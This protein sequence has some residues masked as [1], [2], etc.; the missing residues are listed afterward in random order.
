MWAGAQLLL[1]AAANVSKL[2][3]PHRDDGLTADLRRLLDA[4]GATALRDR[5]LR[6]SFEHLDERI[7]AWS[8][9]NLGTQFTDSVIVNSFD[10]LPRPMPL[11]AF[12]AADF[13]VILLG[14]SYELT[15]VV[16]A[17]HHVGTRADPSAGIHL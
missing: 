4:D 2:L 15:P 14:D 16:D 3:W 17:L 5:S 11:R 7:V 12:I 1:G 13:A 8:R 10:E 9:N 6:N